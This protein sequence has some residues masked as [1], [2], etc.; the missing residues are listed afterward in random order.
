MEHG[1]ITCLIGLGGNTGPVEDTFVAAIQRL[2]CENCQITALSRNFRTAPMGPD[3]GGRFTNA[4]ASLNTDLSP[5]KMLDLLQHKHPLDDLKP[6]VTAEELIACQR[7]I[8]GIYVDRKVREYLTQIVHE[9]RESEHL[10]LGGSPRAS[11]ALFRTSQAMAALRGRR[12]VQ[13]DDVKRI[14]QPV[15]NHRLILKPESRLRK[16]ATEDVVKEIMSEIA[17]PTLDE[18]QQSP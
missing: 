15:L 12:F 9:T 8:R 3:A 2:N 6:V 14:V 16:I 13:P 4:A 10:S 7:A 18:A 1:G 5:L 17:V 11:I